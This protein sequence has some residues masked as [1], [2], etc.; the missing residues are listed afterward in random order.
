MERKGDLHW[1]WKP[2]LQ[3]FRVL[4]VQLRDP[5]I[6][7]AS[8]LYL[9]YGLLCF[10]FNF[11]SH[12][13]DLI[14]TFEVMKAFFP[15]HVTFTLVLSIFLESVNNALHSVGIHL[16]VFAMTRSRWSLLWQS[17]QQVGTKFSDEFHVTL[18]KFSAMMVF[19]VTFLVTTN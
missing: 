19:V 17:F 8:R 4:G 1:S 2:I 13:A 15:P 10:C 7:P 9:G 5:A 6:F 12:A 16:A 11:T 18:R 14:A 3:V